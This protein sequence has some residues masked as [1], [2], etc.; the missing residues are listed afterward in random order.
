MEED[1]DYLGGR[2]VRSIDEVSTKSPKATEAP[3][4]ASQ[5][6]MTRGGEAEGLFLLRPRQQSIHLFYLSLFTHYWVSRLMDGSLSCWLLLVVYRVDGVRRPVKCHCHL[7]F[8][9]E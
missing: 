1:A 7:I 3:E 9:S 5:R 2:Y 6:R 4:V 8:D